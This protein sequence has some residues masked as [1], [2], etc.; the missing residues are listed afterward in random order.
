MPRILDLE[1]SI[2]LRTLRSL[3]TWHQHGDV[4]PVE[5]DL[6]KPGHSPA[7]AGTLVLYHVVQHHVDKV[8]EAQQGTHHLLIIL[9]DDVDP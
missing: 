2:V 5:Q 3:T 7:F 1:A 9:H 6:V 4:V 8:V